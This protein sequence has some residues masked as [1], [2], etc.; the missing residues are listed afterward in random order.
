MEE[1]GGFMEGISNKN[2]F[3]LSRTELNLS[4]ALISR[5]HFLKLDE[6]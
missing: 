1:I 3:D 2:F 6:L 5:D 4:L